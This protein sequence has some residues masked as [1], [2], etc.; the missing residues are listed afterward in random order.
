M[1]TARAA[2][3][4]RLIL[5]AALGARAANEAVGEERAGLRIE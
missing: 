2:V 4:A 5:C 1:V 3:I